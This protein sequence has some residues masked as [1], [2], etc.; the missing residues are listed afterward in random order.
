MK[1]TSKSVKQLAA[2][3]I[4]GLGAGAYAL[5][6]SPKPDLACTQHEYDQCGWPGACNGGPVF[7]CDYQGGICVCDCGPGGQIPIYCC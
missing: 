5:A 1:I 3:G 2:V 7:N 4:L 6:S